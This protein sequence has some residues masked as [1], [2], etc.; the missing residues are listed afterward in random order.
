[1]RSLVQAELLKLRGTRMQLGLVL[2]TLALEVLTVG[3]SVPKADATDAPVPLDSPALLARVVGESFGVPMVLVLLFGVLAITQEFRYGTATSTFL[4]EPRRSRVLFAKWLS[5]L[6]ASVPLTLLCLAEAFAVGV[7]LIE[8]RDGNVTI[9]AEFWQVL[10]A[11]FGVM[12]FFGLVGVAIGALVRSQ[13]AAVVG[14]LVWMLVVEQILNQ[15]Y[16]SVGKW[17][18][19]GAAFGALQLGPALTEKGDILAAPVAGL[20]LLLYAVVGCALAYVVTP[21]RDVL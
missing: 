3:V 13:I 12:A 20:F 7:P 4:V 16:P 9:G 19:A 14:V 15:S 10:V 8:A 5:L 17:L 11:S 18:P 6:V 21:R 1:V 2:A